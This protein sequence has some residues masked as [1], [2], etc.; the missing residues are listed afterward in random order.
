MK[1]TDEE[2]LA[3]LDAAEALALGPTTSE[4]AS[5]RADA[6]D[7]YLGKAYGDEQPGRSSV[8]SRD[9][10][11]VVEGVCANV[12]KPF[13]AGDQI[14]EFNPR[15][16]ED[17][18]AAQQE[19]DYVNFVAL[20]RNNG[21]VVL[22]CAVKDALLLR[23][24]Y[25]KCGWT[26]R[27]DV[28]L[29]TYQ[30]LSDD[31]LN[32]LLQDKD[33]EVAGHAEYPDPYFAPPPPMPMGAQPP[34]QP[35]MGAVQ[36][37]PPPMLHDLKLK[38][39]RPTEYVET[40]P[41]PPNE[42]MV[43]QRST[44]ASLQNADFVQHRTHKTLS[45]LR[46][47]G[48]KVED[49]IGDD[50]DAFETQ[51]EYARQKFQSAAGIWDDETQDKA[52]KIVLFKETW[53]RVDRDGDGIAE[54]RRICTVGRT[55]LDD[56]EAEFIP[57]ACFTSVIMPHRHLGVS[58]YDLIKDIAQIKTA[59][60]RGFLD[61]LYLSTNS[62]KIVN[63]DN[64]V[65]VND[66]LISR[67]GGI[68]RVTGDPNL[69]VV[70]LVTPSNGQGALQ[71]LE[72]MDAVRENRTGYT[73]SAQGMDSNSL[74]TQTATG[75]L[76]QVS[77]SQMRLEMISRT[78]AETGLRDMF[79]LIHALTL[80]HSTREEKVRLRNKWVAVNPRE[81]VRRTD[82]SISVGLGS[83]SGQQQIQNLML[84][85]QAQQTAMPLGIV[86]PTN[87]YNT[88]KKL[89]TAAGFKNP[90]EFFTA[91]QPGQQPP[92]QP[93]P[94]VLAAQETAKGL[95]QQEM[96]K[97]QGEAQRQPAEIEGKRQVAL[98][99]AGKDM[100]IASGQQAIDMQE[101]QAK[102]QHQAHALH[103]DHARQM[104]ESQQDAQF[105]VH[106]AQQQDQFKRDT[107]QPRPPSK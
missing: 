34:Q 91:P 43:S 46:Q 97:Q 80:K 10:S 55:L 71:G 19:T 50:D 2:L 93:A 95:L 40:L 64:V 36:P 72:Y 3:A 22:N 104:H 59:L 25:V 62:E 58:V 60:T 56:E 37:M 18:E 90:D 30:G 102:I 27:E 106:A 53:M 45:E 26:K 99:N 12:L 7:R 92:P 13:V 16:P 11:D 41:C 15:G 21:F 4:I 57:I 96:V 42:I 101:A 105:K 39:K 65:D 48:Y 47:L 6:I 35:G 63:I 5:D 9:V 100:L 8:V 79:R 31:E 29:E 83:V 68:K 33:V 107:F 88:L 69:S 81:W 1:M 20:E 66:F 51:E 32:A 89:A 74:A 103:L 67:P 76:Q 24:G 94:E 52:R 44:E 98:I 75:Y 87:I 61:N 49:E 28:M 82:L 85:G 38:R 86:N 23:N 14:V 54:L 70:P 84:I 17:E 78:I 73:R 77:Q